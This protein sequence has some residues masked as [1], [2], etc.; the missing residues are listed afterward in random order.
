MAVE[1]KTIRKDRRGEDQRRTEEEPVESRL[2]FHTV[3]ACANGQKVHFNYYHYYIH[4]FYCIFNLCGYLTTLNHLHY[5][6]YFLNQTY[7]VP[8][9][10]F[11]GHIG[12]EII[13][14][15]FD[16]LFILLGTL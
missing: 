14:S 1:I 3:L 13:N 6:Y 11:S 15:V 16:Y 8:F 9:C 10:K 12:F 2:D 4:Y 7:G 5:Y